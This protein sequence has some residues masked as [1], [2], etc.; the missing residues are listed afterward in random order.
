MRVLLAVVMLLA[1]QFVMAEDN[2]ASCDVQ[3]RAIE[4]KIKALNVCWEDMECVSVDFGCPFQKFA[5]GKFYVSQ[6]MLA[7]D[8]EIKPMIERYKT[9][10]IQKDEALLGQCR[11]LNKEILKADCPVEKLKCVSGRCLNQSQVLYQHKYF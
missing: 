1:S 10:C 4:A 8:D 7:E 6:D 9:A 5:C 11:M 2:V 3:Q